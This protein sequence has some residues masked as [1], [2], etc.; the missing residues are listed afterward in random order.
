M[1]FVKEEE[2]KRSGKI[3]GYSLMKIS[4]HKFLTGLGEMR[5]AEEGGDASRGQ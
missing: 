5:P 3:S 4:H 2:N 1:N